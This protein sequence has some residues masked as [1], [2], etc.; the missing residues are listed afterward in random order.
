MITLYEKNN[1]EEK[2]IYCVSP[3]KVLNRELLDTMQTLAAFYNTFFTLVSIQASPI[4][5]ESWLANDS[6][7]AGLLQAR[8]KL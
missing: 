7:T 3:M 5:S 4:P 1:R 8:Q 2:N 6:I